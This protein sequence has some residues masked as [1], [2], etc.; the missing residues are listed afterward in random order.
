VSTF[1]FQDFRVPSKGA[2]VIAPGRVVCA[3]AHESNPPQKTPP[4]ELVGTCLLPIV[5]A[6]AAAGTI[7]ATLTI[8]ATAAMARKG[9]VFGILLTRL[10]VRR[11]GSQ[12]HTP[13][14]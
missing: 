8:A 13:Q 5:A 10:T 6:P 14:G 7:A 9:M 4:L 3:R 12:V 11:T 1:T 2:R